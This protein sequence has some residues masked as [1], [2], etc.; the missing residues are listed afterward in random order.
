MTRNL[1]LD[2]IGIDWLIGEVESITDHIDYMGPVEFCEKNRYLPRALT[3]QPGYINLHDVNPYMIEPLECFAMDSPVREVNIMK[4]VQL[5][6]TVSILEN[7]LFYF[8]CYLKSY[9][10]MFLSADKELV[11]QRIENNILPMLQHSG[12]ADIITSHDEGNSRKTGKN[13]DLLQWEG[14]GFMIPAGAVNANKLR[15]HSILLLLKDEIDAWADT[16]GKDGCPDKVTDSRCDAFTDDRK[17]L[18]GSTPLMLHNSKIYKAYNRGDKRRYLVICRGCNFPQA[19]DWTYKTR[20]GERKRAFTWEMDRGTLVPESVTWQCSE[21]GHKHQNHEKEILFRL[22]EGAEWKPTARPRMPNI[23]SYHIPAFY[24]P[25]KGWSDCVGNFLEAYDPVTEKVVDIPAYQVFYNNILGWPFEVIGDRVRFTHVSGHRRSGYKFGQIPNKFAVEWS[26]SPILFLTC[27]VD[28]H[29]RNLAVTVMGWCRDTKPYVIDYWR[30]ED[31]DCRELTSPV[32]TRLRKL[33]LEKEYTADD[34][35]KYKIFCT[36]IDS[37]YENDTV[38][39]YCSEFSG[40]VFP[41]LGRERPAKASRVKEFDPFTTS[42]NTVGYKIVVDH[43]KDRLALVLRREWVE[44]SGPQAKYHFNAPIDI[45]DK[46]L[47]ELT[48]ESKR[49]EVDPRGN[50]IY[51]WYRPGNTPNELW[52]LLV[53]G[54]AAVE[55]I[56]YNICLEHFELDT[57]EWP[58]FWDYMASLLE[59]V[60]NNNIVK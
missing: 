25:F 10:T 45:T 59:P 3:S 29:K 14:G 27:Q 37:G 52:D 19:I 50:K 1:D 54:N 46:Q 26:G 6:Y 18:R 55:I 24:S 13:K 2:K 48:V 28:V 30:Y 32:W 16:V 47:K 35:R 51:R 5:T 44:Q 8:M 43:Y 33:I 7:L 11:K 57:I 58:Q 56:A 42:A 12:F 53:Y 21:C 34:G 38:V 17:I 60:E 23:R 15:S 31:D 22:D 39:T 20:S 4:G 41:I 40:W 49:E 36:L 9:P